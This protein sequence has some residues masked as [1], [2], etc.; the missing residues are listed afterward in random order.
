MEIFADL[1]YKFWKF[2]K[3]GFLILIIFLIISIYKNCSL[4]KELEKEK[5]ENAT[6]NNY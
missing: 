1:I 2:I 6:R 3:I 5:T 4:N